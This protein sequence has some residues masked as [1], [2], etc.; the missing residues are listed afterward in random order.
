MS[1]KVFVTPINGHFQATVLG[2]SKRSKAPHTISVGVSRFLSLWKSHR[3]NSK[4]TFS[5][6]TNRLTTTSN[7]FAHCLTYTNI[8]EALS[9]TTE[10]PLRR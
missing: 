6:P 2:F 9:E 4:I 7:I 1:Y 3:Q 5:A 10:V 8:M